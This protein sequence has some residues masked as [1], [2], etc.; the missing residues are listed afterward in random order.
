MIVEYVRYMIASADRT[1][2]KGAYAKVGAVL[3]QSP[4]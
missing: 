3:N 2:F 1:A 4:Y